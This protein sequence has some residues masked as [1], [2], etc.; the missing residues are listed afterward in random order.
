MTTNPE[1]Q[2]YITRYKVSGFPHLAIIDPRTGALLWK[3]EGWTQVDP[4]T[5]EQF[6]EIASGSFYYY[7][8]TTTTFHRVHPLTFLIPLCVSRFLF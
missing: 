7:F 4:L 3:K 8:H 6:V 1:G 2:T 5:A